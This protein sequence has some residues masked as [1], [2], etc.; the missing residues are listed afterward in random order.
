[1]LRKLSL[2]LLLILSITASKAAIWVPPVVTDTTAIIIVD[3]PHLTLTLTDTQGNVEMQYGIACGQNLGNKKFNGDNKTPEGLFKVGSIA[4]A[5]YKPFFTRDGRGPIFNVYGPWFMRLSTPI[6]NDIGIHGTSKPTSIGSR[7]SWGCI[8]LRNENITDLKDRVKAG[9]PVLI[10][11]DFLTYGAANDSCKKVFDYAF[12][13]SRQ[14]P[15]FDSLI[16]GAAIAGKHICRIPHHLVD[17]QSSIDSVKTARN[18]VFN[19]IECDSLNTVKTLLLT[20]VKADTTIKC[21]F[22][23]T[24]SLPF[25]AP[26]PLLEPQQEEMEDGEFENALFCT[27]ILCL[28]MPSATL[29]NK[30]M[31][32]IRRKKRR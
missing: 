19:E 15:K 23:P 28:I 3:K 6:A 10:L 32:R 16:F 20:Y 8:R 11:Q 25:S 22:Y 12:F 17:I 24:D 27:M 7:C 26:K 31:R 1:M 2:T 9:I 30:Q 18:I 14:D 29:I 4:N 13:S 21:L 5:K